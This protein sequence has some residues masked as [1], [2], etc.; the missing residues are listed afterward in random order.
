MNN[1][2]SNKILPQNIP[3]EEADQ[4]VR[5]LAHILNLA[6]QDALQSLKYITGDSEH[7]MDFDSDC[8]DKDLMENENATSLSIYS[9]VY[10]IISL[11]SRSS[12]SL[13]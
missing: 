1:E 9:R 7:E 5:C 12:I 13:T 4:R 8:G 10:Y 3:F 11:K 6:C 2:L